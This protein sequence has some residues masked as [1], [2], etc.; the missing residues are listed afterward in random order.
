MVSG[1]EVAVLLF[2]RPGTLNLRLMA[3]WSPV[4][5][6]FVVH[7]CLGVRQHL[8]LLCYSSYVTVSDLLTTPKLYFFLL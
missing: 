8:S 3:V 7:M 6:F 2:F 4:L 5:G 1:K